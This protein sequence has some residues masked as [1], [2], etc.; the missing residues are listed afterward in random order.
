[1]LTGITRRAGAGD[2]VNLARQLL[3][4]RVG[5]TVLADHHGD[6]DAARLAKQTALAMLRSAL[7][8]PMP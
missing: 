4:L 7:V 6:T 1:V 3:T 5:A 8:T 2:A